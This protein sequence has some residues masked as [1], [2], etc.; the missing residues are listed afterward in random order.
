MERGNAP[1]DEPSHIES[2]LNSK[3]GDGVNLFNGATHVSLS[4]AAFSQSAV[5]TTRDA[6]DPQG[7]VCGARVVQH[8]RSS[9]LI[10]A[11]GNREFCHDHAHGHDVQ[12]LLRAERLKH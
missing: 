12:A 8:V 9:V 10:R 6:S 5:I 4:Y 3:V 2:S 7:S 11:C 1:D